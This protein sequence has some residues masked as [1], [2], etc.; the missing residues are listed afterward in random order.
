MKLATL[1]TLSALLGGGSL[2][3]GL[4]AINPSQAER[5]DPLTM[6]HGGMMGGM[7]HSGMDKGE[8]MD[9]MDHS[10]MG[11]A[12]DLGPADANY[13]LRFIDGMI[14]HHE[15]AVV[16][17]Q[18]ALEKSQRP[19]ILELAEAIIAA[20]ADEIAQMA[21]WRADWYADASPQLQMWDA[22]MGHMMRM[23][24]EMEANMRMDVSLGEAD[25]DFDLRF[26]EAMIPHHEGAIVMAEDALDKSER[27]EILE[28]AQAILASQQAE[29][30]QMESWKQ[31]WYGQ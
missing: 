23:S 21:N 26:I 11:H 4:L 9:D 2:A 10:D 13:D 5:M 20:Q 28:L 14:P 7:D 8:M 18:E 15:G 29:I 3:L 22:G 27:P 16:M 31:E 24:A 19:E 25:D 30:E 6:N 17:A 1:F 12:M